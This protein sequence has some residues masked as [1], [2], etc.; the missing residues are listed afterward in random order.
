MSAPTTRADARRGQAFA[1]VGALG[2]V[3][4]DIGTSPLYAFQSA[5]TARGGPVSP[6]PSQVYG[7][8]SLIFWSIAL[9]V[10]GKY[11]TVM[12]RADNDGEGGE[13]ALAHLTQGALKRRGRNTAWVMLVGVL[14]AALFYGD[15]VIT[16]A[17]SV[18]SAVEGLEVIQPSLV[19]LV[20]PLAL[21][22]LGG[23]FAA[24]QWGTDRV[25]RSFGPIMVLWFGTLI[26]MA[27]PHLIADPTV[28]RAL[29]PTYAVGFVVAE[30]GIA[31]LAL[32]AVVLAITGAE[33]VYTDM[34]H[35]GAA[36]IRR[37]WF[38]LVFP[39][40]TVNYLAQGQM[41]LQDPSTAENT[42]F[43]MAPQWAHWPLLALAT[44]AT[45]IASQAVIS[46]AFSMSRQCERRGFLPRLNVRQTSV[47]HQGQIYIPIV[48][49]LLFALVIAVVVMFGSSTR[50]AAAYGVAV[51]GTFMVSTVLVLTYAYA[52][53]RWPILQVVLVGLLFGIPEV[54]FF[55][56]NATKIPQ[57]GWLPLAIAIG[58][59]TV[60]LTWRQGRAFAAQRRAE[61]E[62]PLNEVLDSVHATSPSRVP[63]TAVFLH[64][65]NTTAPLG[66]QRS[67]AF[68]GVV[69]EHVL[70]VSI[71]SMNVPRVSPQHRSSVD[72]LGDFDDDIAHV[73]LR[74]GY[75][76][77]VD[78]PGTLA[79]VDDPDGELADLD[80]EHA[81]YVVS[82]ME[83]ARA[84]PSRLGR[85]R[86]Q[87]FVALERNSADPTQYYMLP[88][89]RTMTV[90]ADIEI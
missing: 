12:L 87:L 69:H 55:S 82:R 4:G 53:W 57:G 10:A 3:F 85:F 66:L 2:V 68:S 49:W 15:S 33:A 75:H 80:L 62:Y 43:T 65:N 9:I 79:Q 44:M 38:V 41:V 48:N 50:L 7:L 16:P 31:F 58:V 61:I 29:L 90:G 74:F 28:L 20:V 71:E 8:V 26:A 54:V 42:F 64:P 60:M 21:V 70:I 89:S 5:L 56:A 51:T 18:L 6:T 83:V 13:M 17:I 40:L 34:G 78:V 36:P 76:E 30:P 24:Q 25:G 37:A 84:T 63:G 32:G 45:V 22:I 88:L 86:G 73:T 67:F 23:L 81:F 19:H 14:G 77:P 35:F 59:C 1:S 27:M 72:P 47:Q 11:V 39:A 52:Q 46:G